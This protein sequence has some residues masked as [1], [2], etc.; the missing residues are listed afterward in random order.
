MATISVV[1]NDSR[2]TEVELDL[3]SVESVLDAGGWHGGT[4]VMKSGARHHIASGEPERVKREWRE[5]ANT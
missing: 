1:L 2:G 4:I 5:W 3:A